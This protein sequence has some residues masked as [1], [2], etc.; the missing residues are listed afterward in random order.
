M[1]RIKDLW[2]NGKVV[3]TTHARE[4]MLEREVETTDIKNILYY[5]RIVDHSCDDVRQEVWGYTIEGKLVDG[6]KN[7]SCVVKIDRSLIIITV[8]V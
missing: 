4:R 7:A 5:G 2:T 8:I 6:G 1:S 3:F